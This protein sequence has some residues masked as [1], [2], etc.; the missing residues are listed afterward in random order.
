MELNSLE[1]YRSYGPIRNVDM[2]DVKSGSGYYNPK[3][4]K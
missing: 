3:F 2:I 4:L 1:K